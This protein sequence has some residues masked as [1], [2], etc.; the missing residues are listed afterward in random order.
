MTQPSRNRNLM[1]VFSVTLMSVLGIATIYPVLPKVAAALNVPKA[2]IGKML[3]LFTLPGLV[4]TPVLGVLADR[5]GRKRILGPALLLFGLAGFASGF[6]RSFEMMLALR[7]LQ[8]CGAASLGALNVTLIGDLFKAGE[9][10][11]MMGYNNSVL[12]LGTA[13]M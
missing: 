12:S 5:Y 1:I 7:F 3:A 2:E 10:G 13:T 4:L 6:A 9:R 11:R 8:G